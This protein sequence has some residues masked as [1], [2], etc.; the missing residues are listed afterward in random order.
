MDDILGLRE[1]SI[2]YIISR[3]CCI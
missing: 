3:V 1:R 2:L